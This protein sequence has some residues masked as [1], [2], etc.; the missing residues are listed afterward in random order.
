MP[1]FTIVPT[2]QR[3]SSGEV[4]AEDASAALS[5]VNQLDC[6]EADVLEDGNYLFSVRLSETG[7]WTIFQREDASEA[8]V[9]LG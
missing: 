1:R 4:I 7:M 2:D 9:S 3:Y 6:Q 8:Y 5:I